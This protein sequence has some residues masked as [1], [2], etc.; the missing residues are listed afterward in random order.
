[1]EGDFEN[2]S[3]SVCYSVLRDMDR[4]E[5]CMTAIIHETACA[6]K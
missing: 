2:D 4:Q 5:I 1:M 6:N 3:D